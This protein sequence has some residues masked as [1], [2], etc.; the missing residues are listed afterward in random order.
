MSGND[1]FYGPNAV[2]ISGANGNENLEFD[3]PNPS[4]IN[5]E[6][7]NKKLDFNAP[8]FGCKCN[9]NCW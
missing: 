2:L 3:G 1:D 8:A 6:S 7:R 4:L 5:G 9:I